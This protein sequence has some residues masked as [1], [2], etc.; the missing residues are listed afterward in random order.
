M[1]KKDYILIAQGFKN[2]RA[3]DSLIHT[4]VDAVAVAVAAQLALDNPRFDPQRFL[5][6]CGVA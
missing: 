3:R 4:T 2:A 6:A 5:S 1:S